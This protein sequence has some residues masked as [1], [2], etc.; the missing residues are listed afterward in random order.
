MADNQIG[1]PRQHPPYV[2]RE[3]KAT[4]EK[5][6][7]WE[8]LEHSPYCVDLSPCDFYV[9]RPLKIALRFYLD[10]EM[11]EAGQDFFM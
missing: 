5:K 6:M 11:K 1:S 3:T 7:R 10:N 9:F 8:M 2:S 4:L